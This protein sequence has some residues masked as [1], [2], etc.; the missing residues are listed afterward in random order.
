MNTRHTPSV[1]VIIPVYN[2]AATLA[3]CID[4]V[5]LQTYP[6][7]VIIVVDN[8]STDATKKIIYSSTKRDAR[9]QYAHESIRSRGAARNKGILL[10]KSHIIAMIDADCIAPT[11]WLE[12]LT[13]PLRYEHET[14]VMGSEYAVKTKRLTHFVQQQNTNHLKRHSDGNYT[15]YLDAKNVAML[16]PA[17]KLFLFDSSQKASED[18]ELGIR[19]QEKYRIRFMPDVRVGHYHASSLIT[20][21]AK[22]FDRA[23]WTSRVFVTYKKQGGIIGLPI[24]GA[25]RTN[26]F[27]HFST[28]MVVELFK[29]PDLYTFL[30]L[31]SELFWRLGTARGLR[32][33]AQKI[34]I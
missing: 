25:C 11:D 12:R 32:R 16:T 14:V 22:T 17:A 33:H 6:N 8:A 5:R 15:T 34:E 29:R 2:G 18:F 24:F 26:N 28:K 9:I 1:A 3:S 30:S 27:F 31:V 21:C 10:S 13:Y 4:S 19:L 7:I 23:Y 20:W